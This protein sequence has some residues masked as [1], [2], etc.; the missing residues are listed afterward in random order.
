MKIDYDPAKNVKNIEERGLSFELAEEFNLSVTKT[1]H[2]V[3]K[4]KR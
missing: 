3:L 1:E 4:P 2:T